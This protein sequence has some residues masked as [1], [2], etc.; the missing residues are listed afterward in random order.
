M[1]EDAFVAIALEAGKE[2]LAAP[3][4]IE[5]GACLLY[6]VAVDNRL[7]LSVDPKNPKRGQSAFQTDL[8]IFESVQDIRIP[9]VVLEFKTRLTTH[10]V[11]T[12][13]AKARRHK[14]VYPYLRYGMVVARLEKL[15]GRF[16]THNE[17]LDFGVAAA[18]FRGNRLHQ[19]LADLF[20]SEVASSRQ[21]E[22]IVYGDEA[23]HLYRTGV[24]ARSGDGKVV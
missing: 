20:K 3:L 18:S 7:S 19:L 22:R 12:Y 24:E 21:L 15:P 4:S 9:R 10:D 16:F 6:Q 8:C 11:L 2:V 23:V 14:Q 5:R 17:G 13:S 1:K